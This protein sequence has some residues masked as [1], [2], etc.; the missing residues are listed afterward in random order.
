MVGHNPPHPPIN[1]INESD[2]LLG[3][4]EGDNDHGGQLQTLYLLNHLCQ[5]SLTACNHVQ[6]EWTSPHYDLHPSL[7]TTLQQAFPSPSPTSP[8]PSPF[9]LSTPPHP[10]ID[11]ISESDALLGSLE[12]DN[13]HG[14]QF[15]T[16]DL[17]N[18]LCQQSLT[19]WPGNI[20]TAE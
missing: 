12:G 8:P 19:P 7:H 20:H 4:L 2:T 18:C 11:I 3:S 10:P 17:L 16:L 1:I 5:Q 14:G 6:G 15:Q 13:I 9:H